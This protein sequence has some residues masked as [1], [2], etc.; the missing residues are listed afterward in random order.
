MRERWSRRRLPHWDMPGAAYF[1]TTCLDGS[2]P[3][4]GLLDIERFALDLRK[5]PKPDGCDDEDWRIH[6]WKN[7]RPA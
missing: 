1:V 3:A 2:I 6:H 4:R 5:T 7:V